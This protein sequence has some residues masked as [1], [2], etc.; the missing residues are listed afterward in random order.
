MAWRKPG[1]AH[2][3]APKRRQSTSSDTSYSGVEMEEFFRDALTLQPGPCVYDMD[4]LEQRTTLAVALWSPCCLLGDHSL[5]EANTS[6]ASVLEVL[7][8]KCGTAAGDDGMD[9]PETRTA[10][11]LEGLIT[12]LQRS[13]SQKQMTLITARVSMAAARCQLHGKMW[14]MMSLIAP[15]LLASETWTEDFMVFARDHR[16]NCPYQ[17]LPGVAGAMFD[18]Y[19]RKVL[20]K[21]QVTV[22]KHGFLLHMT[23][24]ASFSVPAMLGAPNF[25]ANALCK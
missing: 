10:I 6:L 13:L 22:E 16:P 7:L 20:Y 24:W 19:T 23:N 17:E 2:F 9:A 3:R 11:R 8:R 12:N 21:S 25:G 18:N 4:F 14:K 1:R 5:T 15:G